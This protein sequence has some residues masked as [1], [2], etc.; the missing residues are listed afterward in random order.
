[1][2]NLTV[3]RFFSRYLMLLW[4]AAVFLLSFRSF[5]ALNNLSLNS[6]N[7]VHILMAYD[8]R[9]PDDLYYWGQNRLGSL[10]P[11]V[12]HLILKIFPLRPVVIVSYVQY[13]LLLIGFFCFAS[14]LQRPISKIILALIWF[15]PLGEFTELLAVGQ[16]YGSQLAFIGIAFAAMNRLI[17]HSEQPEVQRQGLITLATLSLFISLWI[18]D[19]SVIVLGLLLLVGSVLLGIEVRKNWYQKNRV[20]LSF[21]ALGVRRLDL[22]NIGTMSVLGLGFILYAKA[23]A[24]ESGESGDYGYFSTPSQIFEKISRLAAA[25]NQTV[26]FQAKPFAGLSALLILVLAVYWIYLLL[27][28]RA[29][30]STRTTQAQVSLSRWFYLFLDSAIFGFILLL[31]AY[32]TYK[33]PNL[34][35]YTFVYLFGWLT[36]LTFAESLTLS[37]ATKS[38][39]L[40]FLIALTS[41]L[42]LPSD[43]Y[44]LTAPTSAIQRLEPVR[45][46]GNAGFI[47]D[48]RTAYLTCAVAPGQ[49]NCTPYDRKGMSPCLVPPQ[50]QRK[51]G[52]V[53]C[54]RCITKTLDS[55]SIY[56]IRNKWLEQFPAE[57]QQFGQCLVKAGAPQKIGLFEMALYKKR[58]E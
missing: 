14:L 17:L 13:A 30:R 23:H 32:W 21:Q 4:V 18:S 37:A 7:A 31:L 6:D 57:I 22:F 36:V 58:V 34:R 50:R 49:L 44:Q 11:L 10:V 2:P 29:S 38:Y 46:L 3:P 19:L 40:L 43:T 54:K 27:S 48:Y 5:A 52:K 24:R 51:V 55:E 35:Y 53:R 41:S 45:S 25:F 28:Q 42:S 9:W 47:G 39:S 12:S 16:P 56:L 26:S 20:W 33:N 1:M 15:L 8:F